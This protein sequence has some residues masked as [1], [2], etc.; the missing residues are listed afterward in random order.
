MFTPSLSPRTSPRRRRAT[1]LATALVLSVVPLSTLGAPS[2][3]AVDNDVAL[4]PPMGWNTW[5]SFACHIDEELIRD[6]A[7]R[8]VSSGMKDAGYDTVV[9]DDC[10]FDPQRDAA[11][12]LRAAP[13]RFPSGMKA[14]GDY[15]HSKGLKF[16]IYQ[17]PTAL[18][19]AQRN[20][21]YPGA[22]GS[23]GHEQQDANTF[24]SWGVDYLKYDWCSSEGTLDEQIAGFAKMRDALADTGRPIV[25]SINPNSFHEKTGA[26]YD[27]SS[28]ANLW[29][30][31]EDIAPAWDRNRVNA[32]GMGVLDITRINGPLG[33]QAGPGHWNDP[34]MMEV[35][36][37]S[38]KP[39]EY[40]SHFSL[41][42]QMAAPL[43][44]GNKLADLTPEIRDILTNHEVIAVDQD[45]LGK[46]ARIVTQSDTQ[47]LTVRELEGGDWSVT[48]TNTSAGLVTV[49][50]SVAELGIAGASTYTVRELWSGTT[51]ATN[52]TLSATLA[53]H[54][55]AMYRITPGGPID[56]V[57][58]PPTDGTFEIALADTPAQV[59][60]DPASSGADNTQMIVWDRK[61]GTNQRWILTRN[62][63]GTYAVKNKASG[64]CLD[65]R[66][67][68]TTAGTA[69]IQWPCGSGKSNQKFS[70][71]P[72]GAHAY[73]LVA[74]NS[75]LAVT[76]SGTTRGSALTQQ[77][78]A[79]DQTW[80]FIRTS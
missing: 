3:A 4:T 62:A 13:D 72:V 8:L 69:V 73:K 68:F 27:W 46:A 61:H 44:A 11:G 59:M 15:L 9:I 45:G 49:T 16:G 1:L 78:S 50:T 48:L 5:N 21:A 40:R 31:T 43:M 24:A 33:S 6:S 42:A 76:A 7:D 37:G 14:L 32:Y 28:I 80:T 63:D 54:A 75:G 47:L 56:P 57:Q 39:E 23:Q 18:T 74:Q 67:S 77:G 65:I 26:T 66:G 38:M 71:Q 2:A 60:D 17:V 52:G 35:G 19:C 58:A 41:W 30:T 70:L 79:S 36:V 25:Y 64:L 20:H 53:S 51:T 12:N 22:T 10:W 55:T 34:D 29:R